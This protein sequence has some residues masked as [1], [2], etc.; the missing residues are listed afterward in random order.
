MSQKFTPEL[1]DRYLKGQLSE[2]EQL[3]F[4]A[5][6]R[7][8]P[9]L[10]HEI[11][12]QKDIHQALVDTRRNAL[13]SRLDQVPV[14]TTYSYGSLKVAAVV[15]TLLI[16]AGGL[17]YTYTQSSAAYEPFY[18]DD[19]PARISYQ[20]A[21]TIKQPTVKLEAFSDNSSTVAAVTAEK[22]TVVAV[23][24]KAPKNPAATQPQVVSS[25]VEE[26]PDIDYS[27]F[28]APEKQ[29]LQA[30]DYAADDVAIEA[31][32]DSKY[33]FHYQFYDNKL[34]LHGEFQDTPYKIIALNTS[35]DK[36]LFLEF[37]GQY[38]H[39]NRR[40]EPTPLVAIEDTSLIKDLQQLGRLR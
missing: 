38:Y 10:S 16:A 12:W 20:E 36:K 21:Y 15:A 18:T 1:I 34:Y 24:P 40:T 37:D 14:N 26:T 13:K 22:E 4:D 31:L 33:D 6:L 8:D 27:D 39:I 28:E 11:K 25:F 17:Y 32:A 23:A 29:A 2:S 19:S 5:Q 9:L 35:E 7:Q 3:A 30:N